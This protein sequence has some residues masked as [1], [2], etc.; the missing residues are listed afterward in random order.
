MEIFNSMVRTH[1]KKKK[2]GRKK[3]RKKEREYIS[4]I[5]YPTLFNLSY[6]Y[7]YSTNNTS[8]KWLILHLYPFLLSLKLVFILETQVNL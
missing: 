7:F 6:S 5:F 2:K 3:E 1:T 8:Y 4:F